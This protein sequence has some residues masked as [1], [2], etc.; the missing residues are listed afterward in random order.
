ME[1]VALGTVIDDWPERL[2]RRE[3]PLSV[4]AFNKA[5]KTALA[6][7]TDAA[8]RQATGNWLACISQGNACEFGSMGVRMVARLAKEGR[9]LPKE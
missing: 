5:A 3:P 6:P 8:I 4:A 2:R 7:I 1:G 9:D